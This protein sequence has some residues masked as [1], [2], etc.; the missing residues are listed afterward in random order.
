M[1]YL[2]LSILLLSFLFSSLLSQAN[3]WI[4][5]NPNTQAAGEQVIKPLLYQIWELNEFKMQEAVSNAPIEVIGQAF[6]KQVI[7]EL[8]TPDGGIEKYFI[9]H[10]QIM[11]PDLAKKYKGIYTLAAVNVNNPAIT[12]RLDYTPFG[13]H[14]MVMADDATYF[15]DPLT[16]ENTGIYQ[17]Y[18]KKDYSKVFNHRMECLQDGST[19]LLRAHFDNTNNVIDL[20]NARQNLPSLD[21]PTVNGG[22]TH[23]TQHRKY[24]LAL[25][26]TGE[27]AIAVAG[28]TP[29][30]AAVLA[31]MVTS[32]NRVSGIYEKELAITF[33]LIPNN[34]TLIN[35]VSAG[36]PYTNNSGS[37][38]LGQNVTALNARVGLTAYDIGH[39]FSTGGGGIAQLGCICGTSKARGVTGSPSPQGDPFD[40]DYVCHEVGHQF[41]GEHTF[42][43]ETG[44]CSGN[45][46]TTSAFEIGSGTTIMAYAGICDQNDIQNNSN[47]YFNIRSLN[48]ISTFVTGATHTCPVKTTLANTPPTFVGISNLNE[49]I[50]F[51]TFFEVFRKATDAENNPITYCWEQYDLT[52]V[53]LGTNWNNFTG[54][55]APLF[56]S[57]TPVT[58]SQRTFPK[59]TGIQLRQFAALG[60]VVPFNARTVNLRLTARDING[61]Y[62]SFNTSDENLVI[63]V[64]TTAPDSFRITS[65]NTT[66]LQV[67]GDSPLTV[68]WNT[69]GTNTNTAMATP[70]VDIFYSSDAGATWPYKIAS[71][72][73]N[74]GSES[75]IIPNYATTKGRIKVKG[76]G[77]IYFDVNKTNFTVNLKTYPT[78]TTDLA[79]D[80]IKIFPNPANNFIQIDNA[81]FKGKVQLLDLLG[82]TL[83]QQTLSVNNV[84]YT[85]G[86][87]NGLYQVVITKE[88]GGVKTEKVMIQR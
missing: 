21:I 1:K 46:A 27:Y 63:T 44:S 55:K 23:G 34:D 33:E 71:N 69:A 22:K 41:G 62:G 12:A 83:R 68:T 18:Y 17:V 8:P 39:V 65:Q 43:S 16:N 75:V 59:L 47:A 84:I 70:N 5:R 25:A 61:I 48:Q 79:L 88:D 13:F 31:K 66:G 29:T 3:T 30:K 36:D 14:A 54:T 51:K 80:A 20:E 74:D 64:Q 26:C 85:E 10:H 50:P 37:T 53:G 2:K 32:V 49:T 57:F 11:H 9:C 19:E 58:D 7:F 67:T 60:E 52:G 73:P 4:Q 81:N 45:R 82:I 72:T 56:R 78:S 77:N 38:M 24:R 86:L 6:P 15:I 87:A 76:A 42:E 35:L 40:V 28:A